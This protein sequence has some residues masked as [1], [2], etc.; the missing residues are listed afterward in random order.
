MS[1]TAL[2][3][4]PSV[5]ELVQLL[6]TAFPMLPMHWQNHVRALGLSLGRDLPPEE[7]ARVTEHVFSIVRQMGI[8]DP[9]TWLADRRR[10]DA[11]ASTSRVKVKTAPAV[12]GYSSVQRELR[13]IEGSQLGLDAPKSS[14]GSLA[15]S[16]DGMTRVEPPRPATAGDALPEGPQLAPPIGAESGCAVSPA[17]PNGETPLDDDR[18]AS[19]GTADGAA[20]ISAPPEA[21]RPP[22]KS[23]SKASALTYDF[24]TVVE[25]E[26]T[27]RADRVS[28]ENLA[29]APKPCVGPAARDIE[30]SNVKNGAAEATASNQDHC[31]GRRREHRR[32]PVDCRKARPKAVGRLDRMLIVIEALKECPIYRYAAEKAG[33]HRKT[34]KYWL[35]S[36]EAG[37]D[38]YEIEYEGFTLPFHEHCATAKDFADDTLRHHVLESALGVKVRIE[39]GEL[40]EETVAPPNGTMIRFYFDELERPD[41]QNNPTIDPPQIGGVLVIG[42]ATKQPQT[43]P[44]ASIRARRWK[45]RWKKVRDAGA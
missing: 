9:V 24:P 20:S 44:P 39:D 3:Q 41:W 33:I 27:P 17:E 18:K 21:C 2:S 23:T 5:S 43:C 32:R 6:Q 13:E 1:T 45:S 38:G 30:S 26:L 34:L 11:A 19:R 15:I 37:H 22:L 29:E 7:L 4:P 25:V 28:G 8:K 12:A 40:I 16:E 42:D 36:S 14:D 35:R 31:D 10:L